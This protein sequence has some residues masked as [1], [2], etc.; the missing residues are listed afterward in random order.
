MNVIIFIIRVLKLLLMNYRL[1]LCIVLLI[2]I[3]AV[4]V[5]ARLTKIA[6]GAPVYTGEVGLDISSALNGCHQIAWWPAGNDTGTPPGKILEIQGDM[7]YYNF[8]PDI[9]S[10]YEGKWYSWDKKPNIVVFDVQK[11]ELT[12]RI[13]DLDQGKD[14]TGQTI[15][16]STRI[17]YRIETNLYHAVNY[18]YRPDVTPADL[19]FDVRLK[20]PNNEDFTNIYT[21]SAGLSG[22]LI[23]KFDTKPDVKT[24]PYL[25]KDGGSWNHTARSG[26][27]SPL[28][29]LGTYTFTASQNLNN[30]RDY[31]HESVNITTSGP[32]TV[33]FIADQPTT[34]PTAI[35]TTQVTTATTAVATTMRTVVVT[36]ATSAAPTKKPTW[37]STPL[38]AGIT[39]LALGTVYLVFFLHR[40][41]QH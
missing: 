19:F 20:G 1:V 40:R 4:P 6:S 29:P 33:T 37:T 32:K 28:Y 8:S 36:S 22:T 13:W 26:D 10:G 12:L 3:T 25:W 5:S 16:R 2:G 34:A 9:F 41:N 24:S 21:G 35:V 38:P 31:Y 7:Y 27:G 14:I 23:L 11:P 17:T 15:P 39:L 18:L 30:M